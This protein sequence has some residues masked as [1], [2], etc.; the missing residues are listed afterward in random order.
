MVKSDGLPKVP[1]AAPDDVDAQD[2]IGDGVGGH[3][4]AE[5]VFA[6]DEPLIRRAAQDSRQPFVVGKAED[7]RRRQKRHR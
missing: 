7:D 3:G 4:V 1:C 5:A 2:K 6:E